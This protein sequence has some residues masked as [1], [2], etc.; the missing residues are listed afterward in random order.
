MQH[1]GLG[2]VILLKSYLPQYAPACH[3]TLFEQDFEGNTG[4]FVIR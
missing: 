1:D 4:C 3:T 2:A